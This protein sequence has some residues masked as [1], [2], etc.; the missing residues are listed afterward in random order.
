L[1]FKDTSLFKKKERKGPEC[2]ILEIYDTAP[3]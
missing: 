3:I 2:Y 1:G